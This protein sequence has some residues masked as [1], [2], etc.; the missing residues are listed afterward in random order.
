M[1]QKI[2][3]K[4]R[5]ISFSVLFIILFLC[6]MANSEDISSDNEVSGNNEIS[7]VEAPNVD[8]VQKIGIIEE[9]EHAIDETEQEQIEE[10][11]KN[12][13][14]TGENEQ[15]NVEY[16]NLDSIINASSEDREN[17]TEI[18]NNGTPNNKKIKFVLSLNNKIELKGEVE[19]N[20]DISEI[21]EIKNLTNEESWIKEV[22]IKSSQHINSSL[23]DYEDILEITE[24]QKKN[25]KI[26]WVNEGKE[27]EIKEFI[28]ENNDGLFERVSWV[29][30]HLSEQ[31]FQIII[32]FSIENSSNNLA[33]E[34]IKAPQGQVNNP[35][36]FSFNIIYDRLESLNCTLTIGLN[37]YFVNTNNQNFIWPY[38]LPNG[39]YTWLLHCFD[40]NNLSIEK[41]VL[42]NVTISEDF[43]VSDLDSI[44]I[45]GN[46]INLSI[47]SRNNTKTEIKLAHPDGTIYNMII[48]EQYPALLILNES[49]IAKEGMY[50]LNITSYNLAKP[51][52]II[53]NFSVAKI[54]FYSNKNK[55]KVGEEIKFSLNINSP[56]EK[57]TSIIL[58][59]GDESNNISY[60]SMNDNSKNIDFYHRYARRGN[61]TISLKTIIANKIF[62]M[63][64]IRVEIE[65][66][67]DDE[68]PKITLLY[69]EEDDLIENDKI[70]FSYRAEDNVK[71]NNCTFELYN[72]S[73]R[74]GVLDYKE[75][76]TSIIN[77]ETKEI[78]LQNFKEGP[79]SWNVFCCDNSSNCNADLEY[80][81]DFSVELNSSTKNT[82][83]SEENETSHEKKQEITLI[84]SNINNFLV[85]EDFSIEEK[86]VLE[87]LGIL[88]NLEYYKKRLTQID[89]DLAYNLKFI[90]DDAL[91]EKRKQEILEEIEQI[92][93]KVPVSIEIKDKREFV[94]NSITQNIEDIAKDYA[95]AKDINLD[96]TEIKKL[97]EL[98]YKIQNNIDVLTNVK[99]VEISYESNKKEITLIKKE[100]TL[101]NESFDK[102]LEIVPK[103]I[104]QNASEVV[105]ITDNTIIKQ[106]PIFEI[107]FSDLENKTLVYY[108]ERLIDLKDIEQTDTLL[109]KEFSLKGVSI[110]GF[111]ILDFNEAGSFFY[112][113]TIAIFIIITIFLA[114]RCIKKIRIKKWRKEENVVRIFSLIKESRT[115]LE[116]GDFNAAKERYHKIKEVYPLIPEGCKKYLYKKIKR[117][118]LAID[119]KEIFDLVREYEEAKKQRRKE[120]ESVI[121]KSIQSTYKKLP[122]KYQKIIYNKLFKPVLGL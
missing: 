5:I 44:Y 59:F 111:F 73:E 117:I 7:N 86:E 21:E 104:A 109:F 56:A 89:Q 108:I 55:T 118:S 37:T 62:E 52:S 13:T 96:R 16:L 11:E 48:P 91:R 102:I 112:Y 3:N 80:D 29:V 100:I 61:Y 17:A 115:A 76:H 43:S 82:S 57:I 71:I 107:T 60:Y 75:V 54:E 81:R 40:L 72:Y 6:F 69:P 95:D 84:I 53:K 98:N 97:A 49:I 10:I 116:K 87:D 22:I 103:S 8:E 39:D 36:E 78:K 50:I 105:F 25:V 121:Y 114:L 110:T 1:Y 42:G 9:N 74:L 19:E 64:Q 94:K 51:L 4:K 106:D 24:A 79:Y 63:K 101:K 38:S 12:E 88:E 30:P 41:S 68:A 18:K 58:G 65:D 45:L 83:K 33:I 77:N 35:I 34:T 99:Q 14:Y 90:T 27:I 70:T 92:K 66:P 26:Y 20:V 15:N 85:K 23:I 32:N 113:M 46:K 93:E 67:K 2:F 120:D 47:Y 28:D 31:I 122:K 119:K